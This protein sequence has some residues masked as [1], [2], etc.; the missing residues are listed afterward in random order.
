LIHSLYNNGYR[1]LKLA[2]TTIRKVGRMKKNRGDEPVGVI[3]HIYMEISHG[4]SLCLSQTNKNVMFFF[5]TFSL[6]QNWRTG[7]WNRSCP[8]GR[9]GSSGKEGE[10][11]E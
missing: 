7:G 1:N 4:N 6:L 11:G 9:V 10:V 8:R 3:I 5:F 2:E